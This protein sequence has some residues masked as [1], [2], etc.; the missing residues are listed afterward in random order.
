MNYQPPL[1][2]SPDTCHGSSWMSCRYNLMLSCMHRIPT[3]VVS[4]VEWPAEGEIRLTAT[5][6]DRPGSGF[7]PSPLPAAGQTESEAEDNT[8]TQAD[9][10]QGAGA[11]AEG[12]SREEFR[13]EFK[14]DTEHW[15]RV[16]DTYATGLGIDW[17]TVRNV[18][19]LSANYGG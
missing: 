9:S 8:L 11:T 5:P 3:S 6:A 4:S 1:C 12:S 16:V 7:V 17:T 18:M 13:E 19:D 15:S 10:E 14:M 2:N